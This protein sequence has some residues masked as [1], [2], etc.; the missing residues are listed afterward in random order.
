M[1][2]RETLRETSST[3]H[4][5]LPGSPIRTLLRAAMSVPQ[6]LPL[7]RIL[8]YPSERLSYVNPE[9]SLLLSNPFRLTIFAPRCC[10]AS[11][12]IASKVAALS[13]TNREFSYRGRGS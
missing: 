2:D 11:G 1:I 13:P 3:A 7:G 12:K 10:S 8:L 5:K 9:N 6:I 4:A